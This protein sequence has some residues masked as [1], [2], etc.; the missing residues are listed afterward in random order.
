MKRIF[1]AGWLLLSITSLFS[2]S[3]ADSLKKL[4]QQEAVPASQIEWLIKI[5]DEYRVS[6]TDSSFFYATKAKEILASKYDTLQSARAALNIAYYYN[7]N[8]SSDK[9][10]EIIDA[11]IKQLE[12]SHQNNSITAQHYSLSGICLMKLDQKK[13][14]LE[15]F[16]KALQI[17]ESIGDHTTE[18]RAQANIGWVMMETNQFE[19]AIQSIK[20]ALETIRKYNIT[21]I[22]SGGVLYNNMASCFGSLNQLDSAKKYA[23]LGI[24]Y[25]RKNEDVAGEANG[26][27]ILGTAFE[28][29]GK[30]AE[31]LEN[32]QK[33]QPIRE[34][35]GDPF[36]IVSDLAEISSLYARMGKTDEGIATSVK[37]L[38]IAKENNLEAKL[39]MIYSALASNYETKGDFKNALKTYKILN[40]LKDSIYND[41][42]PKALAEMQTRY[43][44]EKKEQQILLQK[45]ELEL[46]QSELVRK[47]ITLAAI[48]IL[49]LLGALLLWS[50][51]RRQ[52]LKIRAARQAENIRQQELATKAVLEAEERE[53]QRIAKD[54]HDGVGQIMSAAKMN[55]SAFENEI[56]FVNPEQKL[57]F[58]KIIDLVDESCKEVRSVSHNMMPNAL[59]KTGLTAAIRE[60]IDKIDYSVLKVELSSEGLNDRLDSN[61]ETV[62]YRVIQECVNNVIKHSGANHLDISLI[63]DNDGISATIE[64][65]GKGFDSKDNSKYEGIGL[66]NIRTR[67]EYLKGSVEFDSKPGKGTLVAIHIPAMIA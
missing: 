2:Q 36:F 10:L 23:Q 15:R 54:L 65:N 20:G 64:D 17:A 29:Q 5:S 66:K 63:K 41:A 37:A 34:K 55:L 67:V 16:Y 31:A 14:A 35:A 12:A 1:I 32:F 27:F 30:Y 53:R 56:L 19:K 7:I 47:N 21:T 11:T 49:A 43:E 46:Q 22:K 6:N 26:L 59:L 24:E 18:V 40:E 13:A 52:Q 38:K 51:F 25:A 57:K 45:S 62:L 58:E 9:S 8:G 50:W 33:A 48:V 28:K 3:K 60:F 42:N 39:P 4:L 61:T 44:T